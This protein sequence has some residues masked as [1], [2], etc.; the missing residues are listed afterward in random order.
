[1]VRLS[2]TDE[3]HRYLK[4]CINQGD[5]VIDATLG[6]GYDA[7]FLADQIGEEGHLFGFDILT[8]ALAVTADRLAT[9]HLAR[10]AELYR[11]SHSAMSE[12]LPEW[13]DGNVRCIM[14]N[15][16]YLPGGDKAL[17]T[18]PDSTLPALKQSASLLASG[19]II[20]I[21]AYRGHPGGKDECAVVIEWVKSLPD[22]Q[23]HSIIHNLL[24][25]HQSPPLWITVEK[26]SAI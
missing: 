1:M 23:F 19:G 2:I 25:D 14:F 21:L 8:D 9:H 26:R 15:L 5:T 10:R 13:V 18:L 11:C 7:L 12:Q 6:N 22:N 24:P 4:Q 17:T 20:S 3:V 16:G